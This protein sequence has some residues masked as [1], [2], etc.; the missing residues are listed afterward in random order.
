MLPLSREAV[1]KLATD[2]G[3]SGEDV[4]SISGGNP[5]YVNEILA[6]YSPGIPENIKDSILAV[7]NRQDE[8]TRYIWDVLSM[9]PTGLETKYLYK[10][11][12]RYEDAIENSLESRILI[13]NNGLLFFKHELYRRTI[14]QS[15]SPIKRVAFNKR[16]LDLFEK[17]F[18]KDNKTERIIHH[19]KN[20]NAYEVVVKY[21]PVAAK[22][23]ASV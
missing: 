17:E 4:Y 22:Q 11:D 20:A 3:Y 21:A 18:E 14:E 13:I 9:L 16:I 5:F 15:L 2:K 7:H 10:I 19:A 1:R 8:K 12:P 23:A 6:S